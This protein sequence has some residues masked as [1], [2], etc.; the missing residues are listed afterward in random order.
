MNMAFRI[1][2]SKQ[3]DDRTSYSIADQISGKDLAIEAFMPIKPRQPAIQR[4]AQKRVVDLRR[5]HADPMCLVV[6]GKMNGPRQVARATVTA[7][8][9]QAPHPAKD[10]SKRNTRRERIA[11]FP[12]RQFFSPQINQRRCYGAN[13][14]S[15]KD[16]PAMLHHEDLRPRLA[17][18]RVVPISHHIPKPRPYDRADD[19]PRA[20]VENAL[21]RKTIPYPA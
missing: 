15:V 10:V 6:G 16:N 19:Q 8:V 14:A 18:E 5:M 17:R 2:A 4:G 11:E 20:D 13:Q 1:I 21:R 9:H 3:F 7:A 12:D